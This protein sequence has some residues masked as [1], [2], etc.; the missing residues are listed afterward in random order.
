MFVMLEKI[1]QAV[2][3][4][5]NDYQERTTDTWLLTLLQH[6]LQASHDK[7]VTKE[8]FCGTNTCV[9]ILLQRER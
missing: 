3:R 5:D 4:L 8:R 1:I 7:H 9:C 2:V 6:P